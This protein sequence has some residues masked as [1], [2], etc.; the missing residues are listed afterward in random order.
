[1]KY[2]RS[3]RIYTPEGPF[4]GYLGVADGK[5]KHL[6]AYPQ[7]PAEIIDFGDL[8]II[9]GIIDTHN[10]GAV[11]YRF[12][13][14]RDLEEV[15]QAL[16][17]EASYGVTG[18][19]PT[20]NKVEHLPLMAQAAESEL[21]GAKVLGIHSE[22]PF[23]TRVGEKGDPKHTYYMDVDLDYCHKM[24]DAG[25]G[26]LKLVAIAPEKPLAL[27]AIHY[28]T[29]QNVVCAAYHT[30]ANYQEANAGI[31]AGISVATHLG[32]VM[33]GLHHRDVGTFGA[34][35]LRDEVTCEQICD[36]LHVS[37]PMIRIVMKVKDHNKIMMVSDN[38]PY[39]G[40]PQGTYRGSSENANNDRATITVTPD[41]Y[42][43][44]ATGRLSGSSKPVLYG[45]RNLVEE[46]GMDLT[47]VVR[48]AALV[49]ARKYQL[50]DRG[51]LEAGNFADFVVINEDYQALHTFV[52]GREVW[53]AEKDQRPF[54]QEF[55][56]E[57]LLSAQ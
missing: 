48:M 9:P 4:N 10:H 47:D 12:Q 8:R 27:D 54:N 43:L 24:V 5:V 14:C 30:N 45:I 11:G 44:S 31:D 36:G 53:N 15:G 28:F 46:L 34:C 38:G 26:W 49:P 51:S 39:L 32:N 22:G 19:F 1:M 35:L 23:G 33:T 29:S 52:E 20:V 41:G 57:H 40:A 21:P 55:L 3:T 50:V 42:V 37:L 56:N 25:S 13:G 18:I 17:G 7:K 16:I 2:Y 6:T